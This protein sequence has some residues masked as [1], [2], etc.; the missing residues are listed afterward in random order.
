MEAIASAALVVVVDAVNAGVTGD[1]ADGEIS[2]RS[3]CGEVSS[4]VEY[5]CLTSD[6]LA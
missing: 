2:G 4:A 3:V 5:H 6:A 1:T